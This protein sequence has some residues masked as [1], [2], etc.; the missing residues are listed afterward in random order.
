MPQRADTAPEKVWGNKCVKTNALAFARRRVPCLQAC[1]PR[2][3][4]KL[5]LHKQKDPGEAAGI[6][7]LSVAVHQIGVG[8]HLSGFPGNW[9]V[10]ASTRK[11]RGTCILP[12]G[13]RSGGNLSKTV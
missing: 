6:G 13:T 4:T 12:R 8:S 5:S 11:D 9:D 10:G 3:C 2:G 1:A 7:G